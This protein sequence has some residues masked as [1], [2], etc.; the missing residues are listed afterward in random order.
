MKDLIVLSG[1]MDST[2]VLAI[3]VHDA[4]VRR[5]TRQVE[6]IS[7]V[8]GQ[9][10]AAE[11]LNA[12]AV[13]QHYG[14][15]HEVLYVSLGK[16]GVLMDHDA[17]MPH[18]SYEEIKE[19]EGVSPTYVPF[20]NGTF[21]SVATSHALEIG[22][23][24]I[25]AGMHAED[26]RGWAYPDCTPEFIGAMQNAIYVGTYHKVRLVVPFQYASKADIVRAGMRVNAPY[27]LTMTCY[28]GKDPACGKCPTCV[29][30][31]AAFD[32]AGYGDPIAYEMGA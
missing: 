17:E 3:A 1:G 32:E 9:R 26:A 25:W 4:L 7:F 11:V 19:S 2:T 13:A 29:S 23:D 10:H 24:T 5:P 12:E 20:R 18:I 30:R 8:Y 28:E 15:K 31:I 27:R 21:L 6:A 22:A 16:Q 14:I